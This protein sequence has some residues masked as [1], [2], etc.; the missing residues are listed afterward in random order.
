MTQTHLLWKYYWEDDVEKF[1]RLL[2]LAAHGPQPAG[3]SSNI[4]QGQAGGAGSLG[5]SPRPSGKSR[6]QPNGALSRIDVNSRDHVG[7]TLLLRAASSTTKNAVSFAEALIEHPAIDIHAQDPESGWNA[8][9]RALYA[10]NISI[11]RMLLAKERRVLAGPTASFLRV[12][13]LI[14]TKDH[15]GNSPFDLYN[16]TIGE[17]DLIALR[18]L[19]GAQD[20]EDGSDNEAEVAQES[21][22]RKPRHGALG[23]DLYTFGSNRNLTLGLGDQDDRQ[24]PERVYLERPAHL[25]QRFYNEYLE[26]AGLEGSTAQNLRDIPA[27]VLNRPIVI[28]DVV[29]SKLHSAVLTT[30]PVSNLYVSGVGRG[31]RLGLGDENTRFKFTPVQGPLGDKKII[32]VALG[33][34]HTMALD[35]SRA[36]WTW[37]S[38]AHS[39]LGYTLPEPTKKDE[40]PISTTPRQVF[41]SLKKESIQGIAASS[42]HSVAHTGISL[43]CWGKNVGQ[44]ALMD[45]DSRSLEYQQTPRKVAASLFSSPIVMVSAIDKATT[46]LLQN[47]TVCVFTGYGYNIVKFP[48]AS[49]DTIGHLSMSNRYEPGRSQISYIT[50]GGETIAA[51]TKRGDLFTMHLDHKMETNPPATSTTNPSKIKGAVTQPQ[52]IWSARKDGVR[53]VGVGEYGSVIISTHSGAVWRRIKRAKVKDA[54]SWSSESKRNDF[55]FQRVPHITKVAAVRASPFGAFAAVRRDLD[56]LKEQLV[57]SEQSLWKDVAPLNPLADFRASEPKP[58]VRN[59]EKVKFWGNETLKSNLG[60]VAYEV[61]KSSDLEEDLESYLVE[62]NHLHQPLDALVCSSSLPDI[63]IPVHAW[64]LSARSSVIRHA[65]AQWRRVSSDVQHEAFTIS[66]VDGKPLLVFQGLDVITLLNFVH[67]MYE[68]K[69]I[70]AWNFTRQAP[71]LAYRYRQVRQEVMRLATRLN[72]HNLE[73]AARLQVDPKKCMDEDF[74]LAIKDRTFFDDGDILLELDGREVAVH[75][76]FLCQRCPWFQVLFHGRSRGIWLATRREEAER[77]NE[78]IGIDL[79]HMEPGAFAYVLRYLYGDYGAELFDPT[80]CDTFA[81]FL[82]LVMDVMSM[83]NYL[84][85]DRLSQICQTIMGRFANIRNIA[86]FLNAI[87]PCSITE[88]RDAGLEYICLQLESMLENHLLDELDD[89]LLLELDAIVRDNQAAQSPFVRSG[90]F[91]MLL[92]EAHPELAQDID[93]ERQIRVKEIAFRASRED[94]RKLST[95]FKGKGGSGVDDASAS[96]PAADKTRRASKAARNEPFGHSPE[97][98]PKTSQADLIFDMEEEDGPATLS[99]PLGAKAPKVPSSAVDKDQFPTLGSSW[100]G[101][102]PIRSGQS[103]AMASRS[104][105]QAGTSPATKAG[106]VPWANA[107]MPASKVGLRDII[108]LETTTTPVAAGRSAL[109]EGL[110]AQQQQQTGKEGTSAP[111]VAQPKLSQKERKKQQQEQAAAQAALHFAKASLA[112]KPAWGDTESKAPPPWKMVTANKAKPAPP[113]VN[114]PVSSPPVAKPLVAAEATPV[115]RRTASPDTRFAGQRT[116]SN[117]SVH[118]ANPNPKSKS[119][120]TL[121]SSSAQ[122]FPSLGDSSSKPIVPHSKVYIAPA[123]KDEHLLGFSMEEIIL[124]QKLEQERIKGAMSKRSLQEIQE[125]Q[126]FQEWWDAE[127]KRLQEE[128]EERK[129]KATEKEERKEKGDKARGKGRG[130]DTVN[131]AESS[132]AG[133]DATAKGTGKPGGGEAKT[134]ERKGEGRGGRGKGGPSGKKDGPPPGEGKGAVVASAASTSAT[135]AIPTGPKGHGG[136]A[137][138]QH[139]SR[140]ADGGEGSSNPRRRDRGR[141]RGKGGR[142]ATQVAGAVSTPTGPAIPAAGR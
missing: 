47:Y 57:V 28:E 60:S 37:G 98:K 113:H 90:R 24:F 51:L 32:Q 39:Q 71:P 133:G 131:G 128:E 27:L 29:M 96:T 26:S 81:D 124:Q 140:K 83:A 101:K 105:L 40:D 119:T 12:G 16:A 91:E 93:E 108:Q 38:N 17:R 116:S 141:D 2:S 103:P 59:K 43:Y 3:R 80:M 139:H 30:D 48:F 97:L 34:N 31:G 114:P 45:S 111:K 92:H 123:R 102:A 52:C 118:T 55:K 22:S 73:A 74:R 68:D 46:V 61:L 76:S 58:R 109:S 79:K 14:K 75:S 120:P 15:E 23:E 19:G 70:P 99:T 122:Q 121:S 25:L 63:R 89:D 67:F 142:D 112:N 86:N 10:G 85:L 125:E 82:D 69:V 35:E 36:L 13:Q 136:A 135:P 6:K 104:S 134:G 7:L 138:P 66:N 94:D 56:V 106:G 110:A 117:N 107:P 72:M 137:A 5:T 11:A 4:T 18:E 62:W 42:I 78:R 127:S 132:K 1:R 33:Q 100:K 9:H 41:S 44:L 64:L 77:E 65:L 130:R 50:S 115:V 95:A 49:M 88:F 126:A 8:L 129:R 54:Y 21:V 20:E 53:S 84:M 87:S